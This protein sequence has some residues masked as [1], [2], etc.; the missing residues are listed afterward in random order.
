M[1]NTLSLLQP[2]FQE[3]FDDDDLLIESSTAADDVDG[4]DSLAHIR[5]VVAIERKFNMRFSASEISDLENVGE[6][7]DLIISKSQN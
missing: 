4:W 7:C 2:I 1:S 3:V 6:M 5:L